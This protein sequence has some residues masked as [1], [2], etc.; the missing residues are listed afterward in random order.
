M[1]RTEQV[2]AKQIKYRDVPEPLTNHFCRN[3]N[4]SEEQLKQKIMYKPIPRSKHGIADYVFVP[5]VYA[6]PKLLGFKEN[7]VA[8]RLCH[9]ISSGAFASTLMTKAEWGAMKVLPYRA[10]LGLDAGITLF[11]LAAPWLFRFARSKRARNT[12]LVMGAVSLAVTLLSST[13]E[14]DD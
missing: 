7:S 2:K 5:L 14:M 9:L 12:F 13:K 6:A 8:A 3:S 11:S 4:S 10:H 1:F